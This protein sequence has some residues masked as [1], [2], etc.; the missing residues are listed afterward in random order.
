[1]ITFSKADKKDDDALRK[2]MQQDLLEGDITVSFRREPS[3][4]Y[5]SAVQGDMAQVYKCVDTDN[6]LIGL[7]S[8]ALLKTYINGKASKTGYLSDLRLSSEHRGGTILLR[9]YRYLK[10]I[11]DNNPVP[12]YYSMIM[13]NNQLALRA[14]TKQRCNLPHYRDAG[15]FLTPAIFLDLKKETI[16]IAGISCHRAKDGDMEEIFKFIQLTAAEKQFAPVISV[17]DMNTNRLRGLRPDD[18]YL[19]YKDGEIIAVI[20]AWDQSDFRQTFIEKYNTTLQ[21]LRPIYNLL[22][23]ISPLKPLPPLGSKVPYF[24]LTFVN[25]KQNNPEIF[26]CLLRYMYNDRRTGNWSYFI[27]GLHE[28]DP[29]ASVLSEYR[30]IKIAGKLFVVH[31]QENE[32]DYNNLD[33]RIPYVEI[34]MI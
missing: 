34:S 18:F 5:G 14:L 27:A 26:R 33:D 3:F 8:R 29:L 17:S 16:A 22:S 11:H 4:F 9:A 10:K 2:R 25:V 21:I 13:E 12:L 19:A 7:G 23:I 30:R 31:Y 28:N 20:A 6:N 15:L 24:Y 32:Q 1:M